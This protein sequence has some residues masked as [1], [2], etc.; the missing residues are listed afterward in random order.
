MELVGSQIAGAVHSLWHPLTHSRGLLNGQPDRIER[1]QHRFVQFPPDAAAVVKQIALALFGCC[2]GRGEATS[3]LFM[4]RASTGL[5][6]V[7]RN[8]QS[9]NRLLVRRLAMGVPK[10]VDNLEAPP[11]FHQLEHPFQTC[12]MEHLR[13]LSSQGLFSSIAH[14]LYAPAMHSVTWRFRQVTNEG[15]SGNAGS[16]LSSPDGLNQGETACRYKR[17]LSSTKET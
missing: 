12:D 11:V 6:S 3:D 17:V 14:C 7:V 8:P 2:E 10:P 13:N 15:I 1:L 5:A 4:W 16:L 9:E